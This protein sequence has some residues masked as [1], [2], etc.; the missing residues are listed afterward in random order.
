M[1]SL[2]AMLSRKQQERQKREE[3]INERI[4][5]LTEKWGWVIGGVVGNNPEYVKAIIHD[6]LGFPI[7][8]STSHTEREAYD[9]PNSY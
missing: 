5:R 2:K 4:D 7:P 6:F 9:N 8:S 3:R 1:N